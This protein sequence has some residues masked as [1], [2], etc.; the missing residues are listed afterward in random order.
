MAEAATSASDNSDLRVTSVSCGSSHSLALLSKPVLP[1]PWKSS[2]GTTIVMDGKAMLFI[3]HQ[4][5]GVG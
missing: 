2:V 5:Q 1:M 4:T 3:C